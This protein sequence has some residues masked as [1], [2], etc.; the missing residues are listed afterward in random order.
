MDGGV[1]SVYP[2]GRRPSADRPSSP[3]QTGTG[4]GRCLNNR[5]GGQTDGSGDG[6]DGG[7]GDLS[8]IGVR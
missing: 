3:W 6:E 4:R 1:V 5:G 2:L 7:S 8:Q